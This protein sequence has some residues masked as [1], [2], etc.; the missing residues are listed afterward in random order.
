MAA[1]DECQIQCS[2]ESSEEGSLS[3]PLKQVAGEISVGNLEQSCC[4]CLRS[5]T[6]QPFCL[7]TKSTS[8]ILIWSFLAGIFHSICT[9]PYFVITR[10]TEHNVKL[11]IFVIGGVFTFYASLQLFYPLAGLLADVRYGRYKCV[12]GS[13]WSFIGG[14]V[15]LSVIAFTLR[16]SPDYLKLNYHAWSYA[17]SAL[18]LAV[19][20]I[21]AIA[22]A[23]FVITSIVA[24][25]ANVIQFGLDQLHDSPTEH[26]VLYIRWYV[27]FSFIGCQMATLMTSICFYHDLGIMIFIVLAYVLLISSLCVG[28]CKRRTWFLT[29]SG[30]RNPYRLV[31]HVICFARKHTYP[32]RR[33]AFTYCEDEL[34]SRLDLGK[35]KYGGPFTTEQVENVTVFLGLLRILL[36]LGP[37]F[38]VESSTFALL[39]VFTIHLSG[40]F[41]LCIRYHPSLVPFVTNGILPSFLTLCLMILYILFLRHLLCNCF[42][43]MLKRMTLGMVLLI[44]PNIC[45]F[46]LDT[47]GHTRIRSHNVGCFLVPSPTDD[48]LQINPLYLFIPLFCSSSGYV[49]SYIAVYDFLCAQS[50]HSMKGLLIGTLFAIRGIFQLLG[51]LVIMFP[52]LG[53]KLSSSFPSCGFAYYLVN[54]AVAIVGFVAFLY[55]AKSYKYRQRDEPDNIFRYAEEYYSKN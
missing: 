51:A 36:S 12:I 38:A 3:Q 54:I 16:S 25:N 52:F 55:V 49:I 46:I 39:S 21:F 17:V 37:L 31:Y 53:W 10:S 22:G 15:A 42:R 11:D 32:I 24:F 13:L 35:E 2:G 43:G 50:P 9:N 14:S 7:R 29:D 40:N 30:S 48:P 26:L 27:L 28:Y 6:R 1:I 47:I 18:E 33:S 4:S 34:P 20:G 5:S 45:F 8:L 23:L 44:V 19:L 41:S